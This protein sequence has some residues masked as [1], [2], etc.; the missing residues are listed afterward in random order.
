[1]N[2]EH[3]KQGRDCDGNPM[4]KQRSPENAIQ[5]QLRG[6]SKAFSEGRHDEVTLLIEQ[7]GR[8]HRQHYRSSS[9]PRIEFKTPSELASFKPPEGWNLVGDYH[10]QRGAP[11][12]IG[13]A[14]G[15][16]KSRVATALAIA[17]ATGADWM[18][19]TVHTRFK[20]MIIQCENGPVRLAE[21]LR[22]IVATEMDDFVRITPPPPMG[23]AFDDPAFCD[24]LRDQIKK[25]QPDVV[26][27]DPWNRVASDDK[28]KD[29]K[30]AFERLLSILPNGNQAPALV[31]VS[32]TRKPKADERTSG[33]GLLNTLAG[34]YLLGSIPR[35]A[36]VLQPAT[37]DPEDARVVWT[38]CKNN[39]GPLGARTAWERLNG[40]FAP[41][42]DF[43]WDTFDHRG[44]KTERRRI[45]TPEL[46]K[47]VLKA[48]GGLTKAELA[49][50]LVDGH[51]FGKTA[52]YN[53]I[54]K[55]ADSIIEKEARFYHPDHA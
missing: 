20:T 5:A 35:C 17:G 51:G 27:I 31:I 44:E 16:G 34:S 10:L 6:L 48:E 32:H 54:K 40:L 14:P 15:T 30:E 55:H 50:Q 38:C 24:D 23:F 46:I 43:D 33:R 12:V 26:V 1:M 41:V 39:D 45:I 18:G 11:C 28:A 7:L 49:K 29:Y 21:E 13:G 36:F 42:E 9:I 19:L 8:T 22:D 53:A 47:T 52:A 3:T 37:D 4:P 2:A 25:W